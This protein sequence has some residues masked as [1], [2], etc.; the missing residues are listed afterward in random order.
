MPRPQTSRILYMNRLAPLVALLFLAGCQSI[1]PNTPDEVPP[2]QDAAPAT[3][4]A[5]AGEHGSFSQETLYALLVAEL[6]GQRNRFDI[7]LGNYVQQANATQVRA[8]PNAASA[9]PNTS[10]RNRRHWIAT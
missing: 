6:A 1:A 2:V 9:S 4:Q 3:E 10:G 8:L 5:D 7:A